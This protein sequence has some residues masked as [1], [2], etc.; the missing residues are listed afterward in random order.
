MFPSR[1]RK[2]EQAGQKFYFCSKA[3][4]YEWNKTQ[5]GYWKGKKI[6]E[7]FRKRMSENHHD[8]SG[9]KNPRW[10]GG[11]RTD[12]DG[13]IIIHAPEH[14]YRDGD[15][16][17]REHRLVIEQSLNRFLSPVEVVHH[18]NGIKN[19]NRVENLMLFS[20]NS[21]HRKFHANEDRNKK[22]S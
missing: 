12:K 22:T 16:Y 7:E 4:K 15:N 20:S 2:G 19:D 1:V 3:C 21:E 11:R 5:P 18:I 6:P 13:Y 10:N 9:D 8:V 14:P 17:V